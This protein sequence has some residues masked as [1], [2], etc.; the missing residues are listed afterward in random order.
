MKKYLMTGIA[1]LAMCAGFTSCSHDLDAPSQEDI[2]NLEAQKIS[3]SYNQAFIATF[4]QPAANQ[5]WGFGSS[6]TRALT[7]ANQG[8]N[9]AETSTGINANANEWADAADAPHGHGGWL[10]PDPLTNGQKE[11]VK[12]YFQA[13]PNLTY[14]D[15]EWRHFFVQQVYKGGPSTK[16]ANSSEEVVAADGSKYTSDNMNLLTVGANHQHINNF[17]GGTCTMRND[18]LDNGGN[19]NDGPFHSDQIM[20]MVNIDDTSCMGYHE[21]G[22]STHHDNKAA[23]V[24]AAVIDEWAASNGNP[25]EAVTDKWNRSFVGF[26][27][28][29]KEGEQA[30]ETDE[31]GNVLYATYSQAAE[32]PRFAWMARISLRLQNRVKPLDGKLFTKKATRP[33]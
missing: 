29:I 17:N 6:S 33:S 2:N 19:A 30:Y 32:S 15:P 24:S 23:L 22:S 4:G 25:G 20:L 10:V 27:L 26:D 5:N 18:V 13:N 7:R 16:G 9:Y 21:T 3:N 8:E 11:R 31:S 28:A 1:A 14:T 12:A